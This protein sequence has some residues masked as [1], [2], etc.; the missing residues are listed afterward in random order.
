M[1]SSV[2]VGAT[3]PIARTSTR[4]H[5]RW[6]VVQRHLAASP[7]PA[8]A[9]TICHCAANWSS[10]ADTAHRP[11]DAPPDHSPP[12]VDRHPWSLLYVS[13]VTVATGQPLPRT[14]NWITWAE[15]GRAARAS[16]YVEA[17]IARVVHVKPQHTDQRR[18]RERA[19]RSL[20]GHVQLPIYPSARHV[21]WA[22]GVNF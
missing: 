15:R 1:L 18:V 10:P 2:G 3:H 22:G 9:V 5:H 19:L 14:S 8:T 6:L 21:F 12:P 11:R 7:S 4:L 17:N 20:C 13:E 16:P